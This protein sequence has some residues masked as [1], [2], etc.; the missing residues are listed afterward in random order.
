MIKQLTIAIILGAI[1]G[2]GVTTTI[3]NLKNQNLQTNGQ[4]DSNLPTPT[5][6]DTSFNQISPTPISHYLTITLP[7]PN[8]VSN[9]ADITIKGQTSP[10]ST[11]IIHTGLDTFFPEI[12]D[13]GLFQQ[14]IELEAGANLIQ[15]TSL[16]ISEEQIDKEILVTFT[17]AEF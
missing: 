15:L 1:V 12:D 13:T 7:T 4:T 6:V 8:S 11:L 2:F 9:E 10:N 16:S 14:P 17:T 3:V 5:S